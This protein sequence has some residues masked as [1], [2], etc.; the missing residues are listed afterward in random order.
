MNVAFLLSS[1]K[2]RGLFVA[3]GVVDIFFRLLLI[4]YLYLLVFLLLSIT[5][6]AS[7]LNVKIRMWRVFMLTDNCAELSSD[8]SRNSSYCAIIITWT[9]IVKT[10]PSVFKKSNST[11][12]ACLQLFL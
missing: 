10:E 11:I 1:V 8:L 4:L 3:L 5:V 7:G 9:I 12:Y 2:Q 6:S